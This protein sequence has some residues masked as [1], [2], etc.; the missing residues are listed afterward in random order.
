MQK[1]GLKNVAEKKFC[2]LLGSCIIQKDTLPRIRL[3]GRFLEVYNELTPV[4][5]N[6]YLE[7]VDL[8]TQ[9]ILNFKIDDDLETILIPVVNIAYSLSYIEQSN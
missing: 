2:Q 6:R 4:E 1:Y 7:I 5:Y 3:F 9:Q 8:Y